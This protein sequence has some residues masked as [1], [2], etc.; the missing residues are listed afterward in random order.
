MR[1]V[2]GC[3]RIQQG[4]WPDQG[5]QEGLPWGWVLRNKLQVQAGRSEQKEQCGSRSTGKT[6]TDRK[7]RLEGSGVN[8]SSS[9]L[10]G[11]SPS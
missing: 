9:S 10:P 6:D 8:P 2:G 3:R 5:M 4:I 11:C 7:A 1:S